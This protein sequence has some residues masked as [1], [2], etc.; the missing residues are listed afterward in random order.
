MNDRNE[1]KDG[2]GGKEGGRALVAGNLVT[3]TVVM[4]HKLESQHDCSG[5]Y[6]PPLY[7]TV[8]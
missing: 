7:I 2:E 5:E 3:S 6:I 1:V 8:G 4:V